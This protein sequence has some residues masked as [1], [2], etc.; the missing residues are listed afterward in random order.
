MH[1][2][3]LLLSAAIT[4]QPAAQMATIKIDTTRLRPQ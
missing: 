4:E 3:D 1:V 2:V